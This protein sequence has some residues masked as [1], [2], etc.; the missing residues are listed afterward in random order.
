LFYAMANV[1]LS[2]ALS[3]NPRGIPKALFIDNVEE[4]ISNQESAD[5]ALKRMQEFY[6]KY[7]YM[8]MTLTKNRASLRNKLPEIKSTLNMVQYL[9][10][11]KS[12]GE[13]ISTAYELSDQVFATAKL[14]PSTVCLWLGANVMVEYTFEEALELLT[15]NLT[16]AEKSLANHEDDINFLKDQITTT[17]VNIARVYNFDVKQRRKLKPQDGP[18]S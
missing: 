2:A 16:N 13:T 7:K 9:Q 3:A 12:S 17:E 5:A 10:Q 8:E 6:S 18:Q 14:K 15:R 4:F 11:K 1:E